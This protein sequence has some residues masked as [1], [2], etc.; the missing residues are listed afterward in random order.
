MTSPSSSAKNGGATPHGR[1][2]R[3]PFSNSE[4]AQEAVGGHLAHGTE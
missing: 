3:P 4:A 1:L 2:R